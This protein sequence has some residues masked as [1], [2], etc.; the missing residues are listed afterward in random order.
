M[1]HISVSLELQPHST[2]DIF[3]LVSQNIQTLHLLIQTSVTSVIVGGFSSGVTDTISIRLQ[4]WHKGM[5]K[6]Q[7]EYTHRHPPFNLVSPC[8]N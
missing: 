4:R 8:N 5:F 1:Y 7:K 3:A 6:R 2:P